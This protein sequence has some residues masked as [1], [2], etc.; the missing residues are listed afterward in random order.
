MIARIKRFYGESKQ[1]LRHV[2]WPARSEA[3]RLTI[4][5]IG[6]SLGLAVFLGAFDFLF[7]YGLKLFVSGNL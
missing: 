2:N 6:I 4:I 5:V 7:S 3:V 1:E